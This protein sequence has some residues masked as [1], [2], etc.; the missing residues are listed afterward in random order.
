M[1][2]IPT[3]A[4][5]NHTTPTKERRH[6]MLEEGGVPS[7]GVH[8]EAGLGWVRHGRVF[9]WADWRKMCLNRREV[10]AKKQ[11]VTGRYSRRVLGL[12]WNQSCQ[13]RLDDGGFIDSLV[14]RSHAFPSIDHTTPHLSGCLATSAL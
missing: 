13:D 1:L 2:V 5:V 6:G 4:H 12:K 7:L 9:G 3:R 8:D 10:V 14:R 11:M